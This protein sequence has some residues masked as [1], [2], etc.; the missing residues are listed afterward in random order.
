MLGI[1]HIRS[2]FPVR[3]LAHSCKSAGPTCAFWS[4][5]LSLASSF[6]FNHSFINPFRYSTP[7]TIVYND[8]L[9]LTFLAS[10]WLSG[11]TSCCRYSTIGVIQVCRAE[12]K[13]CTRHLSMLLSLSTYTKVFLNKWPKHVDASLM[14]ASALLFSP[15]GICLMVKLLRDLPSF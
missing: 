10:S 9:I 14:R 6:H 4:S 12:V 3:S 5:S 15:L 2:I 11:R 7:S 1:L 8:A 13:V